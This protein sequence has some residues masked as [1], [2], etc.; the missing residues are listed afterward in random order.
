M[1][2][3]IV[4]S[5]RLKQAQDASCSGMQGQLN[6]HKLIH[7]VHHINKR[8][9]KTHM[10]ISKAAEKASAKIQHPLINTLNKLG[11]E[12]RYLNIIKSILD[13]RTAKVILN[14]EKLKA[15]PL[16]SST[17]QGGQLPPL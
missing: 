16:R 17:R 6:A 9:E 13:K 7:M 8:K 3:I 5:V 4:I 10:T 11:T 15:F 2:C 12:E 14:G 1:G